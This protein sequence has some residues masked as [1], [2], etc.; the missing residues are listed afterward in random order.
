M[1]R[2]VRPLGTMG[3]L[4]ESYVDFGQ[5]DQFGTGLERGQALLEEEANKFSCNACWGQLHLHYIGPCFLSLG[6][7]TVNCQTPRS[8]SV[9]SIPN[10]HLCSNVHAEPLSVVERRVTLALI[11]IHR[12]YPLI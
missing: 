7:R 4:V 8:R 3:E 5:T 2:G 12:S 6:V 10:M 11:S 9:R 1:A